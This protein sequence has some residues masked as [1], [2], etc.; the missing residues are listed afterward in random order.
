MGGRESEKPSSV[1]V[2]GE[3]TGQDVIVRRGLV[4]EEMEGDECKEK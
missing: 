3:G 4:V 1:S 2:R